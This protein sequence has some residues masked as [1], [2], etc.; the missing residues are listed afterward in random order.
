MPETDIVTPRLRLMPFTLELLQAAMRAPAEV[1]HLCHA[2]VA[3]G[4]P[5]PDFAEILPMLA[6]DVAR[7]P[8][9]AEW[10]RTIMVVATQT[11]IGD[12]G[13]RNTPNT[14]ETEI[15]YGLV[16]TAWGQGF[17]TEAARGMIAWAFGQP[18][19]TAI[20]AESELENHRSARVLEKVGMARMGQ[21]D[22][23][24]QWRLAR[25]TFTGENG[26]M[27]EKESKNTLKT[28]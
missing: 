9:R 12:I 28:P 4:W 13:F 7:E 8:Q 25:D 27:S 23:L 17:A 14:G 1:G 19:I 18:R 21:I 24:V 10:T 22:T 11:I 16:S 26:T 20:T 6:D 2:S 5:E 3:P 15:G